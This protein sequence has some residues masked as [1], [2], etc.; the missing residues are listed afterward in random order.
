MRH[1]RVLTI[2]TFTTEPFVG[3][4]CAVF[5]D[6][7]GLTDELMQAIAR[8]INLSETAFVFPSAQVDFRVR[9]FTPRREIPFAGHPT[10]ATAYAVALESLV[11]MRKPVTRIELEFNIGVLPVDIHIE[12]QQPMHVVMTHQVPTFGRRFTAEQVAPCFNLDIGDLRPD[13]PSQI[14]S[15]GSPFLIVPALD[16]SVLGRVEMD[17]KTLSALCASA[18]VS[19][20]FMFS[21]GGFDPSVDTHARLFDPN[22]AAEDP[23]TGSASGAMGAYAVHYGLKPGPSLVAEQGHFVGRPG[24]GYLEIIGTPQ[25]IETVRLGGA[26]VKVMEGTLSL[27]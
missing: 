25:K 20:A 5:P 24:R 27:A 1:Y 3:N 2:D 10:I 21:I 15:T 7:A 16:V 23:F 9:Y 14:V 4:P 6:A 13:C 8:E 22:G 11:P 17:R 19:A 26:A 12:N 18:G